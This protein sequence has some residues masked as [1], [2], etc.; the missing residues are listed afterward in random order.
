MVA[1][2]Q[3]RED[4][5]PALVQGEA[6]SESK[7]QR[8]SVEGQCAGLLQVGMEG[9]RVLDSLWVPLAACT[10]TRSFASGAEGCST[11]PRVSGCSLVHVW[12]P[13]ELL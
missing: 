6:L 5:A 3:V 10:I 8:C 13:V 12:L 11:M 2:A 7:E 9:G 4:L 1:L